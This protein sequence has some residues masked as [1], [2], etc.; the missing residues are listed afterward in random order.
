MR[1]LVWVG[2]LLALLAIP[3]LA[4]AGPGAQ[5]AQTTCAAEQS[6]M[7]SLGRPSA[8]ARLLVSGASQM[9]LQTT[10]AATPSTTATAY[11]VRAGDTLSGIAARFGTSV[12]ALMASNQ[13]QNPNLIFVGQRLAI[14]GRAAVPSAAAPAPAAAAVLDAAWIEGEAVQG[15][16]AMI[17]LRAA[18]G[19]S[20]TGKLGEQTIYFHPHCGLLWGL[21]AF[22]ALRDEPG[23]HTLNL[24]ATTASGARVVGRVPITLRAGNFWSGPMLQYPSSKQPLLE[25]SVIDG[26][27][28]WL[29]QRFAALTNPA[30]A[31]AWSGVFALP[32]NTRLTGSFGAR[33]E[34]DGKPVGYHEGLDYRGPTGTPFYAPAPG[35]VVVAQPLTV[36]G[37]T[38]FVDHGAG[39]ITGYFHMSDFA[40]EPGDWVNTGEPLG[41]T[42]DSGLTTGPH[43]HWEVRVNG[44]WVNPAPWLVRAVP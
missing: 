14:P 24:T 22:D 44:R 8:E 26:E 31:P 21:V 43:L 15:D 37:G 29:A 33:G 19:T 16:A 1:R 35:T 27:N 13:I 20:V 41:W 25:R 42:G 32:L 2:L 6:A 7:A 39:V 10:V 17:W 28:R 3:K 30:S 18:T 40:V 34:V 9:G 36:R 5:V 11:A 38:V 12:Y 23:T 4:W